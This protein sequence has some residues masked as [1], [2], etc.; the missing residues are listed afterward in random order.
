MS[1]L[2]S[3]PKQHVLLAFITAVASLVTSSAAMKNPH[4]N[5]LPS[6]AVSPLASRL[7]KPRRDHPTS[8]L[9]SHL[10]SRR[11]MS[12]LMA[13]TLE[14]FLSELV[15]FGDI[16]HGQKQ[17]ITGMA[18]GQQ[19]S[20]GRVDGGEIMSL[21]FLEGT[22]CS[23]QLL[24]ILLDTLLFATPMQTIAM[25]TLYP[26]NRRMVCVSICTPKWVMVKWKRG[27]PR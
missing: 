19:A 14:E 27:R 9:H 11:V 12:N 8:P 13:Q 3:I 1:L 6:P 25:I 24:T 2:L 5:H 23:Y 18:D 4:R 26:S 16:T 17:A 15:M 10:R 21:A 22:I 20:S 7:A